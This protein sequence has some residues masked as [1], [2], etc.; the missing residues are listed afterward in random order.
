M[1][2]VRFR[3]EELDP[4]LRS[5][6]DDWL[7]TANSA[8]DAVLDQH[9]KGEEIKFR[10][11]VWAGFKEW[12]FLNVFNGKCAY[13]EGDVRSVAYGDAEHWR[14]KGEV[15]ERGDDGKDSLVLD[16]SGEAH[17]GY[18]WAAYDWKNLVPACQECNSGTKASRGK[19]TVFPIKG[20]RVFAPEE[21]TGFEEMNDIEKPLLLHPFDESRDPE[22][23]I[24]FNEYG[25]PI[26]KGGSE[27]GRHSI[28]VLNLDRDW[29][30]R[31]RS[32]LRED[33]RKAVKSAIAQQMNGGPRAVETLREQ[34]DPREPWAGAT[35]H[36]IRHWWPIVVQELGEEP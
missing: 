22:K 19:L 9:A 4:G 18:F 7:A 29:Q 2:H 17:Q 12:L 11:E 33:L 27:H 15:R 14:P 25:Q 31:R 28:E 36:Y 8:T 3:P 26:A 10:P 23:H 20:R 24:G 34:M 6:F 1:I 35:R 13:C 16:G 21:A 5:K 32:K 30:N